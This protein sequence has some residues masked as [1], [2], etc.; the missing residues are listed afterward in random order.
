MAS[1]ADDILDELYAEGV[2]DVDVIEE[3]NGSFVLQDNDSSYDNHDTIRDVIAD[4]R[5]EIYDEYEEDGTYY[6]EVRY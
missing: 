3:N 4:S 6:F 2:Q 1:I 5:A